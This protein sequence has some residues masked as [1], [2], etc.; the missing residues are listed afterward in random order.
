MRRVRNEGFSTDTWLFFARTHGLKVED[1]RSGQ[2][3]LWVLG[4]EQ[5]SHVAAQLEAWGFKPRAPR[6]WFKE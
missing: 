1:H 6:G 3:A 2:G 5:P 4:V